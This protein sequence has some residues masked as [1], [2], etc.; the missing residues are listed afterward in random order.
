M[1][2][3]F[4]TNVADYK[5]YA[6]YVGER[7]REHCAEDSASTTIIEY[8]LLSPMPLLSPR[9]IRSKGRAWKELSLS[10]SL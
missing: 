8:I 4:Q 3:R 5:R 7:N 10:M 2:H 9:K 1:D 6:C